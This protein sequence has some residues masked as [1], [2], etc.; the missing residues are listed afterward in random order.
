MLVRAC[1]HL[2]FRSRRGRR[3][4]TGSFLT[5]DE[6]RQHPE[7]QEALQR[8]LLCSDPGPGPGPSQGRSGS[9][10]DQPISLAPKRTRREQKTEQGW[11]Q[12]PK[13][14][15]VSQTDNRSLNL[16]MHP[17][18]LKLFSLVMQLLAPFPEARKAVAEA[19][20]ALPNESKSLPP[21]LPNEPP[22]FTDTNENEPPST[23][24][25]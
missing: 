3:S 11:S 12:A 6:K 22:A 1:R 18:V 14:T 20:T 13:P 17:E 24:Q 19:L 7:G 4:F 8:L 2:P 9:G 15:Y 21:P 5:M 25:H 16:L 10:E 23:A